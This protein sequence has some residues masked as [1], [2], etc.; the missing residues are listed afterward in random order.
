MI[1]YCDKDKMR[2]LSLK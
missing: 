2:Y 1:S